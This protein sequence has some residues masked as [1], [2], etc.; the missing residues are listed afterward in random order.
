MCIDSIKLPFSPPFPTLLLPPLVFWTSSRAAD[1]VDSKRKVSSKQDSI[2][3]GLKDAEKR[4][5]R[6]D[7]PAKISA[8]N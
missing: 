1:E 4:T 6:K 3:E 7:C 8:F 5:Q 2:A